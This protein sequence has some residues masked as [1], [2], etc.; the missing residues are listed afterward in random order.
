LPKLLRTLKLEQ[1]V[2]IGHS[3]GATIALLHASR[4]LVNACVAMAPH[5]TVED[6]AI[7]SIEQ[8]RDAYLAPDQTLRG[9]LSR[10]HD[11]VDNAFWQWN[12]VWL[13]HAFRSFDIRKDCSRIT[14]PLLLVQGCNDEYGTLQQLR[15]IE[16]EAPHVQTLEL[17]DCGHSPHR[18]T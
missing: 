12:D 7:R 9:R 4:H 11:D 3:D 6:V 15:D 10:Y 17:P 1:P 13:S 16:A 2:L 5:V 18:D 14:A 8:A